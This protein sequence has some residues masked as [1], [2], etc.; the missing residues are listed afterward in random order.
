[1]LQGSESPYFQT[2]KDLL[3]YVDQGLFVIPNFQR[4]FEWEPSMVCD[5]IESII[6]NY[7]TGLI[8][9]W[10]LNH[11][12]SSDKQWDLL[13]GVKNNNNKTNPSV[14]ILDGQQR[15]SSLYY[16][17]Y[18]PD[19]YFPNRNSF[20]TFY[21]NLIK[22]LNS[23]FEDC[24]FYKY[25]K[26]YKN[27]DILREEFKNDVKSGVIPLAILSAKDIKLTNQ[28]YIYST[29][30]DE[31]VNKFLEQNKDKLP[32]GLSSLS[33]GNKVQSVLNYNFVYYSLSSERDLPDICNIF[34]RVNEK[35]MRLSI[36]D[37][38][39]AFLYPYDV[40]LRTDLWENLEYDKLKELSISNMPEYILK[41]M[42][43]YKQNYCSSKYIYWLVPE[44]KKV[45][46]EQGEIFIVK[47]GQ[48]FNQLW[49]KAAKWMDKAREIMMNTGTLDIGA[50]KPDFIPNITVL[51]VIAALLWN[52]EDGTLDNEFKTF[53]QKFVIAA[54]LSEDY[55]GSSDTVMSKDYREC[56]EWK[57]GSLPSRLANMHD[58]DIDNIDFSSVKKGSSQYK[59]ILCLLALNGADDFFTQRTVGTIDYSKECI[60]DHHIFPVKVK[61]DK[62]SI[63][64]ES[65][66][67]SILNRTLLLD[68]TNK[69]ILNKKPSEY[70]SEMQKRNEFNN[71]IQKVKAVLH[72]HFINDK[73]F[74]YLQN[75]DYDN[76]IKE[77]ESAIKE[78]IKKILFD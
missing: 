46:L 10:N 52:I 11:S 21:I 65:T 57:P 31:W 66:K 3:R 54:A 59:I 34:T 8:M 70:L 28:V 41:T 62:V 64:F 19:I 68:E 40:K 37:L 27:W 51:S 4:G 35:G 6:Q 47:N 50:I 20:Y 49:K 53:L 67:D 42:S 14:A 1:M 61:I 24:V 9:G 74:E 75:D 60:N 16:A 38:M 30:F 33:I 76:F 43:L 56:K 36:F 45:K 2:V 22:I 55:S 18:N 13:W 73:A 25:S 39:N 77:R 78:H 17:I 7:Y 29:E 44:Q 23:E 71:D 69:K 63:K 58:E 72:N 15:L 32:N 12:F 48:E 26:S 5:L